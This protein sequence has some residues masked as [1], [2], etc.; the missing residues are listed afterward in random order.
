MIHL[1]YDPVTGV[2][3]LVLA[4]I[5]KLGADVPVRVTFTGAPGTVGALQ[6]ALGSPD[7]D[8]DVLAYTEDFTSESD[9]VWTALLDASDT[10]LATFM[11]DKT[12]TAV[13]AEL[14]AVIDGIRRVTPNL[15]VTVQPPIV[16][17]PETSEGGPHYNGGADYD[18]DDL[19]STGTTT[20]AIG[21]SNRVFDL[22]LQLGAGA[23]AYTRKVVLGTTS[24]QERDKVHIRAELPAHANPTLEIRNGTAGGTLLL[25]QPG[26]ADGAVILFATFIFRSGAWTPLCVQTSSL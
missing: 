16:V 6:L 2:A 15:T 19:S 20:P 18:S 13:N 22:L 12:A 7:A 9:R 4:A 5:I 17:G 24:P 14:V 8:S 21:A 1:T 23:G 26:E 3:K 10:R 11:T 25:T